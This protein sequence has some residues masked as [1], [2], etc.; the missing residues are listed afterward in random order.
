MSSFEG[1]VVWALQVKIC[2]DGFE[3]GKLAPN[4]NEREQ[5]R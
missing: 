2:P 3:E 4:A 5:Y 1:G